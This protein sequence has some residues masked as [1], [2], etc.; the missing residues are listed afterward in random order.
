MPIT[1]WIRETTDEDFIPQHRIKYFKRNSD[2]K[3]VWDREERIDQIFGSGLTGR[4]R[5]GIDDKNEDDI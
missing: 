2:T 5:A 3:I 1:M 4:I